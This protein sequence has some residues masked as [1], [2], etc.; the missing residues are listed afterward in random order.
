MF[1]YHG[2]DPRH[3]LKLRLTLWG[4]S[5]SYICNHTIICHCFCPPAVRLAEGLADEHR[6]RSLAVPRDCVDCKT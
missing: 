5:A 6:D 4:K 3:T 2:E 1:Q